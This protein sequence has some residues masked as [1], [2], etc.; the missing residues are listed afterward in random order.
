MK[1]TV[2]CLV[3]AGAAVCLG[4]LPATASAGHG[5]SGGGHSGGFHGG[6]FGGMGHVG[7][8]GHHG[9]W[10][11]GGGGH[12]GWH[13]GLAGHH[14]TVHGA[15]SRFAGHPNRIGGH[16]QLGGHNRLAHNQFAHN[17]LAHNG[18]NHNS[19]SGHR[20]NSFNRNG[21]NRNA[22]GNQVAWNRWGHNHWGPG[23]NNWGTGWGAWVA[24]VFWPYFYGD[25]LTFA[26]WPYTY[27]D[28]FWIYGPDFILASI[29]WPGPFVGP[30][31]ADW[32]SGYVGLSDIYGDYGGYGYGYAIRHRHTTRVAGQ[33]AQVDE[34]TNASTTTP[35]ANASTTT[36]AQTCSGLAPGV[37]DLPVDR[38]E[39][40][41]HPTGDQVAA[42]DDLKSASSRATDVLKASCPEEAPLTPVGRL[43]AVEKRFSSMIE[44]V[45]VVRTPLENFY[46]SLTDEQRRRFN[47]MGAPTS[48]RPSTSKA[49][50]SASGNDLAALCNQQ[51]GGFT[52]LP[53]QR[54]EQTIRPTQQQQGP[55]ND[56]KTA[57]SKA[58]SELEASCP[59]QAPQAPTDRLDAVTKR[60]DAMIQAVKIVRP[61]LDTFY[62]SLSDE[63]K[64]R[65]NAMGQPQGQPESQAQGRAG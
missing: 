41:V 25:V 28:P 53:L 21:F 14:L 40:T 34:T 15:H 18:F 39:H 6:H 4:L 50:G 64:A 47:A 37:T 65:F 9:G 61:A 48:R 10:A 2:T 5:H 16:R 51:V 56:L 1:K 12:P 62:V 30:Y 44:A 27:Y 29:F 13:H 8:W 57:S 60:L 36:P 58:A 63:Q 11:R 46:N 35:A 45:Q 38:I 26:L 20:L 43:D 7:G 42:L 24:P 32:P 54:I 31:Y 23:W 59:T 52:Q 49:R 3:A 22:F 17:G 19:L 33:P 55:L